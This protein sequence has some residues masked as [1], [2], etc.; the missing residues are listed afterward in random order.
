MSK[1]YNNTVL[2][3]VI[4]PGGQGSFVEQSGGRIQQPDY[5]NYFITP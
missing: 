1:S 5:L 2:T 4:D 3:K